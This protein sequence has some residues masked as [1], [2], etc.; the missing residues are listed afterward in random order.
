MVVYHPPLPLQ[1]L[2]T[3]RQLS[4][5]SEAL[6]DNDICFSGQSAQPSGPSDFLPFPHFIGFLANAP[7]FLLQPTRFF[8]FDLLAFM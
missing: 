7:T 4:L 6:L 3:S 5:I 8:F 2:K 1:Q